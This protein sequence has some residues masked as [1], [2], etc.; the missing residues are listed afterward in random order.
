MRLAS[1]AIVV[2]LVASTVSGIT[3]LVADRAVD[4]EPSNDSVWG[5]SVMGSGEV[6]YGDIMLTRADDY[7]DYYTIWAD[8]GMV[9]NAS[10]C[11]LDYDPSYPMEYDLSLYLGTFDGSAMTWVDSSLTDRQW[12]SV[13]AVAPQ[14]ENL[15]ILVMTNLTSDGWP[16]SL[17]TSYTVGASVQSPKSIAPGGTANGYLE[18]DSPSAAAW[19]LI[20]PAPAY[21]HS[22]NVSLSVSA[23]ADVDLSVHDLWPY[24]A[25]GLE[26]LNASR[27]PGDGVLESAN[28]SGGEGDFFIEVSDREGWGPFTL[29]VKDIGKSPDGNNRRY[30]ATEVKDDDPVL[31]F[32]DEGTNHYDW[33]KV[34]LTTSEMISKVDFHID[35]GAWDLYFLGIFNDMGTLMEGRYNTPDGL[36]PNTYNPTIGAISYGNLTSNYDGYIYFVIVA[37]A[38]TA[39]AAA[40]AFEPASCNYSLAFTL[41]NM[42]PVVLKSN[43][44]AGLVIPEDSSYDGL[45]VSLF[46]ADP[47]H[48]K[49]SF[50]VVHE[51]PY[52]STDLES[53]TGIANLTPAPYWAGRTSVDFRATDSG[54]GRKFVDA[55]LNVI[56]TPVNHA[57]NVIPGRALGDLTLSEG[58]QAATDPLWTVFE[59]RDNDPARP[60]QYSWALN[61]AN[62]TPANSTPPPIELNSTSGALEAG[63]YEYMF[64]TLSYNV[65]ADDGNDTPPGDVP[66]MSLNITVVHHNHPPE[67]RAGVGLPLEMS[68]NEGQVNASLRMRAVVMDRDISYAGDSLSYNVSGAR[69][70]QAAM[71]QNGTLTVDATTHQ[72]I[73]GDMYIEYLVLTATDSAGETLWLNL[74]VNVIPRNDPPVI[75]AAVPSESDVRVNEGDRMEFRIL[76]ADPDTPDSALNITWSIGQAVAGTGSRSF[77]WTPDYSSAERGDTFRFSN[78][79]ASRYVVSVVVSDGATNVSQQWKVMVVDVDRPPTD[80]QIIS[81]SNA[82]L[83]KERDNITFIA[84]AADPD[85]DVLTFRWYEGSTELGSGD[86]LTV[87][88]LKAGMHLIR[89]DVSDGKQTASTSVTIDVRKLPVT[90]APARTPGFELVPL[91]AALALISIWRKFR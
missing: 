17:P 89:L 91:L 31:G 37:I 4:S 39:S 85:G 36:P 24:D 80:V 35:K 70:I 77:S 1:M 5:A 14:S 45:N 59:D 53:S 34:H 27:N 60:V 83:F 78:L 22:Y 86:R 9:V 56:V 66:V 62:L 42:P 26:L 16:N 21:D 20:S 7:Y 87:S 73:P 10:L 41:P 55:S 38:P 32:L 52:L 40:P 75:T 76:V 90:A 6:V 30:S 18:A 3:A 71:D 29:S 13:S 43:I 65:T 82:S 19:Y 63:P 2:L 74:T 46:F 69:N 72:F 23:G 50:T 88:S 33:Y 84:S 12:E 67:L 68:V 44:P 15:Y 64:G 8:K 47:D 81:P 11:L 51:N 61:A 79:S 48:D 49:L 54:P 58:E 57:P 28:I 25:N